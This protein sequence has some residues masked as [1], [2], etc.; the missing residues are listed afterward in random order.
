MKRTM[1]FTGTVALIL[2]LMLSGCPDTDDLKNQ[3]NPIYKGFYNYP[4]GRQ[5]NAALLTV[6]N[7]YNSP[8]LLFHTDFTAEARRVII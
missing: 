4:A 1:I 2:S 8:V 6:T 7:N 3:T 5:D